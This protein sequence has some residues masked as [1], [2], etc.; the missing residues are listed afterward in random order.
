M[1][2]APN[3]TVT[4]DP[5]APSRPTFEAIRHDL[6][7]V[8]KLRLIIT[9]LFVVFAVLLARYSWGFPSAPHA[10]SNGERVWVPPIAI[11]AFLVKGT[12]T[13]H[14]STLAIVT[15]SLSSSSLRSFAISSFLLLRVRGYATSAN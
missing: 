4:P 12:I 13:S 14:P 2:K 7:Q 5:V 11:D 15:C 1:D 8:P 3:W 9:T 10:T 6:A